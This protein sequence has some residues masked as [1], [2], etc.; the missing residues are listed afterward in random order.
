MGLG[1]VNR[2][3]SALN[4]PIINRQKWIFILVLWGAADERGG[5][6]IPCSFLS[7]VC[8]IVASEGNTEDRSQR[9]GGGE[10]SRRRREKRK[11]KMEERENKRVKEKWFA[12]EIPVERWSRLQT[13]N[14]ALNRKFQWRMVMRYR[15]IVSALCDMLIVMSCVDSTITT[16]SINVRIG[17]RGP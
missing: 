6:E 5:S 8:F 17:H 12:A 1:C 7:S 15:V 11:L 13:C 3:P 16:A 10:K 14:F 9:G 2:L 4:R